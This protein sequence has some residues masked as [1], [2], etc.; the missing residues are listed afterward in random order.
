MTAAVVERQIE[1]ENPVY[2]VLNLC[3][4]VAYVR[5][6]GEFRF[7]NVA[8]ALEDCRMSMERFG[9]EHCAQGN[10]IVFAVPE[11]EEKS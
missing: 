3:R 5:E 9:A 6:G 1:H 10:V 8:D 4:S 11:G 2:Y 7:F